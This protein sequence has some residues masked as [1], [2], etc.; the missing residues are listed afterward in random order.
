MF[1]ADGA[2][3]LALVHGLGL[4]FNTLSPCTQQTVRAIQGMRVIMDLRN[5]RELHSNCN[6]FNL[7]IVLDMS[8]LDIQT[9]QH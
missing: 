9:T 8:P 7:N 1:A 3:V 2:D 5:G 6:K 4:M